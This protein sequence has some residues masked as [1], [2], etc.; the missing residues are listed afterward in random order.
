MFD[1]DSGLESDSEF[2]SRADSRLTG[3][4]AAAIRKCIL[5]SEPVKGKRPAQ[6]SISKKRGT[7][8]ELEREASRV[9]ERWLVLPAR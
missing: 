4:L 5:A 8:I 1:E 3:P 6:R 9:F 2:N 7:H